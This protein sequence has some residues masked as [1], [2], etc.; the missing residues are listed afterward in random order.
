MSYS[1]T[2]IIP[3]FLI[4]ALGTLIACAPQNEANTTLEP[5]KDSDMP[6]VLIF[7]GC[8]V[9]YEVQFPNGLKGGSGRHELQYV[10]DDYRQVKL[11]PKYFPE[12]DT[13]VISVKRAQIELE[14]VYRGFDKF[15]YL[16]QKGDT[17][18]FRYEDKMPLARLLNREAPTH[19]FDFEN[20]K[21]SQVCQG[22]YPAYIKYRLS[23]IYDEVLKPEY[24]QFI[25]KELNR[26]NS[27]LDSIYLAGHLSDTAYK[28][29]RE[30]SKYFWN[31][32]KVREGE[33]SPLQISSLIGQDSLLYYGYYQYFLD[34]LISVNYRSKAKRIQLK[35]RF[36]LDYK[37]TYDQIL[38]SDSFTPTEQEV[39]L[40]YELDKLVDNF[41]YQDSKGFIEKYK[42]H[43]GDSLG[44]IALLDKYQLRQA[45]QNDIA[46][47][48]FDQNELLFN[49]LL[50]SNRGNLIYVD[51]WA[52]WCAPCRK[53]MP[54]AKQLRRKYEKEAIRFV[55][56]SIDDQAG[57]WKRAAEEEGLSSYQDNYRITNRR[58]SML[59]ENLD[60]QAIPRY[61][62]FDKDGKLLHRNA[63]GPDSP[64]LLKLIEQHL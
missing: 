54:Q 4:L 39:L 19:E 46:L 40:Y 20:L 36:F 3:G 23:N 42:D 13:I 14:H 26:E 55:Y 59:M 64:E 10:D 12:D 6:I 9:N 57:K 49:D 27:L 17:V 18:L 43:T 15:S 61:L 44:A 22:N 11:S 2:N 34:N 24:Q 16:L 30:K 58:I 21:R 53:A 47:T 56:F 7:K 60:I 29:Y 50:V 45:E 37:Q 5:Q 51:F 48:D 33:L 62:L 25:E 8:P 63:P 38:E 31:W 1:H 32:V 41:S 35:N 52:S 28:L